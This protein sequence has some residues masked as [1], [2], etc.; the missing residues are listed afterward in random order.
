[1]AV[2]SKGVNFEAINNYVKKAKGTDG[3]AEYSKRLKAVG[4]P[5]NI[6]DPKTLDPK[7]W[8]PVEHEFKFL[9]V[10]DQ[11][12]GNGD[13]SRC[14]QFGIYSAN[15][16][17]YLKLFI[18]WAQVSPQT[19]AKRA[20]EDWPKAYSGSTLSAS[21]ITDKEIVVKLQDFPS[22]EYH[23]ENLRGLFEG[24]IKL[25]GKKATVVE[26]QCKTKGAP[27]CEFTVTLD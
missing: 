1:M 22:N 6:A 15:D 16:I 3:L 25:S 11:Y 18:K 13:R 20:A 23:C 21:V 4:V 2:L 10:M 7:A 24:I 14:Y 12:L 26:S 8:Y 27:Y 9:S 19:V 17:G 5:T